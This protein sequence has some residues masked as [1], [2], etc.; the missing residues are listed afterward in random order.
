MDD[1]EKLSILILNTDLPL[2]PGGGGHE[3]LIST[4]LAK[5]AKNVG[6][7]SQIHTSE[8][9]EKSID[10]V[11][12]GIQLYAWESP[13]LFSNNPLADKKPSLSRQFL[14]SC[15]ELPKTLF[16]RPQ[17]TLIHDL[18]FRN[19]A[20]PLQN[21][22][23]NLWQVLIVVQSNRGKYI[24]YLPLFPLSV[25]VM[26]DIRSLVYER[27]ARTEVNP[28][29]KIVC[30]LEAFR[31][32]FFEG[33]YCRKYDLVV[34]V[35]KN[36]EK[37]VKDHY[38][39]RQI[40]TIPIVI[41]LGY[42]S[43]IAGIKEKPGRIVFTGMMN[44]PPNVDAAIFFARQ[45]FGDIRKVVPQAEFWIVGRNPA[46]E[47]KKLANIPG[48][49]VTG[50]VPDIRPY[51]GEAS[52]FVVPLRFGSGV[53]QKILEAWGMD[54]AVIS[55]T[56]G[57]EG[58]NYQNNQNILIADSAKDFADAAIKILQDETLKN[59]ICRKGKDVVREQHNPALLTEKFYTAIQNALDKKRKQTPKRVFIDLRWMIPGW[60]G[61]I[62]NLSRSLIKELA[63]IE[64]TNQFTILVPSRVKYDLGINGLNNF[65]V[66][67]IDG[68]GYYTNKGIWRIQKFL[69][70]QFH[71]D[72]W[73]SNIV[74]ELRRSNA[75]NA[76]IALSIPGF[77]SPDLYPMTNVL[78]VPDIQH[79]YYPE[80]FLPADLEERH[81]LYTDAINRS[82]IICV[83]SEF[84]RQSLI[85]KLGVT[86]EKI[87]TTPLAVD[88]IFNSG[89]EGQT[90]KDAVLKKYGLEG[91]LYFF[92]PGNTWKHK[93]HKTAFKALSIFLQKT[94]R[95]VIL[96]CTGS[97]KDAQPELISL[98]NDLNLN[99][100]AKFLGYC[101]RED[102]PGLYKGAKGLLFPS[103]FE[104]FGMPIL[105][106]MMCECPVICS[107]TSS[108]P[109]IAG[110]AAILCNPDSAEEFAQ[111]MCQVMDGGPLT[112]KLIERGKIQAGKYSWENFARQVLMVMDS[113]IEEKY[114]EKNAPI[115]S[116]TPYQKKIPKTNYRQNLAQ[117]YAT[118]AREHK[119]FNKLLKTILD[120]FL[121]FIVAPEV[122]FYALMMPVL[123]RFKVKVHKYFHLYKPRVVSFFSKFKKN[124]Y[125]ETKALLVQMNSWPDE[126]CGPRLIQSKNIAEKTKTVIIHGWTDLQYFRKTM[127]MNVSIDGKSIGC[128]TIAHSGN[129]SFTLN[130]ANPI[131]T[132][133]HSLGIKT[134]LYFVPHSINNSGDYRPLSY[135]L[136]DIE[137]IPLDN[138]L[139][140]YPRI[141][142]VTPSYNHAKFIRMTVESVLSQNYPN[143]EYIVMDGGSSD[144]TL[145]I[146]A[147]YPGIKVIS[148]KDR[149][150]WDAVNKGFN[151]ATGDI[152]GFI[153]S[154][155]TLL[156]G[157]LDRIAQEINP[158]L[159]RKVVMGRCIFIDENGKPTGI[160]HPSA[161]TNQTRIL[162]LWKGYT[163]PQPA[164]FWTPEV[165]QKCGGMAGNLHDRWID[166]DLFCR[167][168]KYYQFHWF[169]QIIA[170]YRLHDDS[171]TSSKTD[172][173]RFVETLKISK[174]YWG[175][176]WS[177][178]H[179]KLAIELKIHQ[180]NL[181]D[182]ARKLHQKANFY[183][184]PKKMI[185]V[186][187]YD[188]LAFILAPKVSFY[189]VFI[190]L[191][192]KASNKLLKFLL[193]GEDIP[194]HTAAV[195]NYNHPWADGWCGPNV[196]IDLSKTQKQK[197]CI[198]AEFDLR[199]IL[200][201]ML[202]KVS[203]DGRLLSSTYVIKSGRLEISVDLPNNCRGPLQVEASDWFIPHQFKNNGDFRP[204][205]WKLI[206]YK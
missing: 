135:I 127:E 60:A 11:N 162:E 49:Y 51:L 45:I 119:R 138:N 125:P 176:V 146:L 175:P 179:I 148:E 122:A 28:A 94:G 90:N 191:Y 103:Y 101:P 190:P 169:N 77:L 102:L 200:N 173:E 203:S 57:A 131:E 89:A 86:P 100:R 96:V 63:K 108:L 19:I 155:D 52:V 141:T 192:R 37:W 130:L 142:V 117:Y 8:H 205:S 13:F 158:A 91:K 156:P 84:T 70:K 12:A 48:V 7:V 46:P 194:P 167:F 24:D 124:E 184:I 35:S 115:S 27:Q 157:S 18:Q 177:P 1:N 166:Y 204:L 172:Q 29:K 79:E 4:R 118:Q 139:K 26:H 17:D 5:L 54:K 189:S 163:I 121:C 116:K 16:F 198:L 47:V 187:I 206:E 178:R 199:Y 174:S 143:L 182:R 170:T 6:L 147:E 31:Y 168:A 69:H 161:F 154:D 3:Y 126:W 73:R 40:I 20:E 36:D 113:V 202:I 75:Y 62:E 22:L 112:E 133:S 160:E 137:F 74:E 10:L 123:L 88:P 97:L 23:R 43:P 85:E 59:Q 9:K 81:R 195:I 65:Q 145:K 180:L 68:P 149:G 197:L 164:V 87:I 165:W 30:Y 105:E 171:K 92:F 34:T 82:K 44:H 56:I 152:W 188:G 107:N 136:H 193:K 186:W 150:H 95:D 33:N 106:A 64:T 132:G 38:H 98:I 111:A 25:L 159:G 93:N 140:P 42:F 14:K 129:F 76:D 80:F 151:L 15:F 58:I 66:Q 114:G 196:T 72:F 67:T 134:N 39:P 109:E 99:G 144:D 21:A 104:G 32:H 41:D 185:R 50:Q 78:V 2:F 128:H 61:G 53:R 55:T 120:I 83:I 183:R 153:N 181:S 201:P 71:A 110:D